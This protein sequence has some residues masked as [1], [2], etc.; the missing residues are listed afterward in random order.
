MEAV[1]RQDKEITE[2]LLKRDADPDTL[3]NVS[4]ERCLRVRKLVGEVQYYIVRRATMRACIILC[5]CIGDDERWKA[6]NISVVN[7]F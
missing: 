4:I 7:Y 6:R 5:T 2:A 1:Q 3:N